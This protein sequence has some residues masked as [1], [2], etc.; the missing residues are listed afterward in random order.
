MGYSTPVIARF[1]CS[2]KLRRS[3]FA[4]G[5][6]SAYQTLSRMA[7]GA[8][9]ASGTRPNVPETPKSPPPIRMGE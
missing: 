5:P 3:E 1:Q 7:R 9:P 4:P 8:P 2:L 6:Q